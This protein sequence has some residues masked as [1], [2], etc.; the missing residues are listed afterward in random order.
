MTAPQLTDRELEIMRHTL[1]LRAEKPE[2]PSY[3]NFF[4]ADPEHSDLPVLLALEKRGLMRRTRTPGFVDPE[5]MIFAVTDAGRACGLAYPIPKLT[6]SQKRYRRYLDSDDCFES[7]LD[8]CRYDAERE[9]RERLGLPSMEEEARFAR[10]RLW[11]P[12][13][14]DACG[15]TGREG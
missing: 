5:D 13:L 4:H 10:E 9:R 15:G 11:G 12:S 14:G 2:A 7:F 3:R 6:Q 8:F 1:G